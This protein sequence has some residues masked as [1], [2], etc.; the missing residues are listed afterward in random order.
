M[1]SMNPP[2]E[3]PGLQFPAPDQ[4]P[5]VPD[6]TLASGQDA[7][8]TA[9]PAMTVPL[10]PTPSQNPPQTASQTD[11]QAT[12]PAAV[13][14]VV[15]DGDLIEKEWV[16]KAKQIVEQNRNDPYKQSEELTV[17]RADYMKKRYNKNIKVD[18]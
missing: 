13:S 3:T 7:S 15:D 2:N 1:N 16:S 12:T 14:P 5:E 10:P 17:F 18:E 4:T 9:V 6:Q 11:V 8:S